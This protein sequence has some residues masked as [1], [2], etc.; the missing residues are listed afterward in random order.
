[1]KKVYTSVICAT[2]LLAS[3][4]NAFN[5]N[6]AVNAVA[7]SNTSKGV[8]SNDLIGMLV[9]QL[10]V[11]DKQAS[12]GVGS[13]LS[14]AKQALSSGD[15]STLTNAIPDSE[16]LLGSAPKTNDALKNI[17][18]D[19]SVSGLASLA[20]SFS[21]LGLNSDMVGKFV[22]VVMDYLKGNGKL[23]AVAI[24]AKLFA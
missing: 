7:A 3:N 13:I 1:M 11:S 8:E 4:A 2:L 19:N 14:Y 18:K 16:K 5:V 10:G 21:S 15:F 20:S 12:G 6:Q 17:S 22:P 24:L 23:D 9:S